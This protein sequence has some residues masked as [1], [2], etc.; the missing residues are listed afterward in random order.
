ME[1]HINNINSTIDFLL[2]YKKL[3]ETN[4]IT[5]SNNLNILFNNSENCGNNY[6]ETLYDILNHS[7]NI[8]LD[9]KIKCIIKESNEVNSNIKEIMPIILYYFANKISM[10]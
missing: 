3:I 5:V 6:I 4:E 1:S 7:N 9:S 8:N 10:T 2:Q